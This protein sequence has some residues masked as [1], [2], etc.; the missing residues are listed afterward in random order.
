MSGASILGKPQSQ[1]LAEV[2][3]A[4]LK[5]KNARG[6]T[7]EDLGYEI[8]V[9]REMAAQYIAGEA[10]MG[11]VKWL[12]A[13]ERFPELITRIEET[14]SERAMHAR[15]L[16]L[17]LDLPA[18]RQNRDA[19]ARGVIRANIQGSPFDENPFLRFRFMS[20]PGRGAARAARGA[21]V[22]VGD[23]HL[24]AG[25]SAALNEPFADPVDLGGVMIS[26][27]TAR[28]M[29]AHLLRLRASERRVFGEAA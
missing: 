22:T 29:E 16:A 4:L 2:G 25:L 19:P 8:G 21:G 15:Q 18:A 11:F 1:L 28:A 10:E 7:L 23:H 26:R 3:G 27:H 20:A 6:L 5:I 9:S 17:D 24:L 13:T 14:A 12:R